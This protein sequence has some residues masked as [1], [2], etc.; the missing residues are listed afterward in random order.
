MQFS[1]NK[2]LRKEKVNKTE[3]TLSWYF[4]ASC[5][6]C[7]KKKVEWDKYQNKHSSKTI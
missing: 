2:Y 5:R 7:P 1:N 6:G 4:S 3:N